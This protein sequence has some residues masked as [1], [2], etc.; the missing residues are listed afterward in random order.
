MIDTERRTFILKD[1][2]MTAAER[3]EFIISQLKKAKEPISGSQF[4]KM[5]NVSRQVIV[6]DISILK[7]KKEPIV[8]TSQ[9]YIYFQEEIDKGLEKRVIVCKHAPDQTREELYT[10]VDHGVTVKNVIVE[11]PV[12]GDIT[13]DLRLSNRK[14]VD[15]FIKKVEETNSPYLLTLRDGLHLHTIE[16]DSVDKLDEVCEELERKG[17]LIK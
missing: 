17:I 10:I 5:T 4:A 8:A 15:H 16:A 1:E 13:A 6:Q 9:G 14:E 12:Y 7:A 3:Q 2:K 11:H